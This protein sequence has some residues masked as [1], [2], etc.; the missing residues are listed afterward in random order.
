MDIASLDDRT[1]NV[2]EHRVHHG[3]IISS[4]RR[5]RAPE[6]GHPP[7]ELG[8]VFGFALQQFGEERCPRQLRRP[9]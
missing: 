5:Y 1:V 6:Q 2:P 8:I 4:L 7:C 3:P 9:G